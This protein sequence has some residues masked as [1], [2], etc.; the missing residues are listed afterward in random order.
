MGRGCK[1]KIYARV[2][3]LYISPCMLCHFFWLLYLFVHCLSVFRP[4]TKCAKHL[5]H[6]FSKIVQY[7]IL[8][9]LAWFSLH[10]SDH[11]TNHDLVRF[12]LHHK[13]QNLSKGNT[14]MSIIGEKRKLFSISQHYLW[15]LFVINN[16]ATLVLLSLEEP[17]Y[18][19]M[20]TL[21]L[22]FPIQAS[23]WIF[24]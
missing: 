14:I 7:F 16:T 2:P 15:F 20:A 3:L 8:M 21:I 24:L 18:G 22:S 5:S 23:D 1:L 10:Y 4:H 11:K 17:F 13:P 12:F 9:F 6:R 19:K